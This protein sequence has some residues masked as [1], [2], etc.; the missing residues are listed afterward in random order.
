MRWREVPRFG[1][2]FRATRRHYRQLDSSFEL[3]EETATARH[4]RVLQTRRGRV[5]LNI[6]AHLG[7]SLNRASLTWARGRC[8]ANREVP[9][10]TATAKTS[11]GSCGMWLF[12]AGGSHEHSAQATAVVCRARHRLIAIDMRIEDGPSSL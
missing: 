10:R 8:T 1:I 7:K 4:F 9:G 3:S 2:P 12:L 5:I 6:R 11:M